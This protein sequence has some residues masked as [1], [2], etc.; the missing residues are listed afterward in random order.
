MPRRLPPL[1][2]LRAF[3]AAARHQ[4]FRDAAT[5]LFVTPAAISHQIKSLEDYLG[6]QLFRRKGR[7]LRLT[8]PALAGLPQLQEGFENLAEAVERIEANQGTGTLTVSVAPTFAA[9][10][11]VPRMHRFACA[12]PAVDLRITASLALI[13]YGST[14]PMTAA[15]FLRQGVDVAIRFGTG[16]Y[17]G[18]HVEKL[19]STSVVPVCSPSLLEGEHPLREPADLRYHTLLHDDTQLL[20]GSQPGWLVWLNAAGVHDVDT[21][22]GPRLSSMALALDAAIEGQG[23]VLSL[24]NL[25]AG[26]LRAGRLVVPFETDFPMEMA[27]YVVCPEATADLGRIVAFRKW[28]MAEALQDRQ[29]S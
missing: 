22:R 19:L 6:V 1:N 27:Y 15:D 24:R 21:N 8:E 3:E 5:E 23:V 12:C 17:P 18:L 13:D 10:W 20:G 2:A 9:K 4:S 26:D 25:V 11:L 16:S 7:A 14:V 28:I 29:E